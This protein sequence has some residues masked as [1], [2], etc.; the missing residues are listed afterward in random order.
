[1]A[2]SKER[3]EVDEPTP[4][5]G[6]LAAPRTEDSIR[7]DVAAFV[8][9]AKPGA[10]RCWI[11][12]EYTDDDRDRIAVP[13]TVPD[14]LEGQALEALGKLKPGEWMKGRTLAAELGIDD[15]QNGNFRRLM[16]KLST[17]GRVES[18]RSGYRAR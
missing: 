3:T 10:R 12:V 17:A 13:L 11:I 6:S 7:R 2:T 15:P 18:S 4:M 5:P 16:A 8:N 9:E 14:D 1:M